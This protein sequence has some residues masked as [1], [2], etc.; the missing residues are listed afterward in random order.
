MGVTKTIPVEFGVAKG[1]KILVAKRY[2]TNNIG[3]IDRLKKRYQKQVIRASA[4]GRPALLVV[5]WLKRQTIISQ[6]GVGKD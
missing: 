5:R 2:A 3:Y 1:F 4:N 6:D